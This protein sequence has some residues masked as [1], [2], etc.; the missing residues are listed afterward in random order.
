MPSQSHKE[1]GQKPG[2]KSPG[3][4]VT[5]AQVL[6]TPAIKALRKA[7]FDAR[8]ASGANG[9]TQAEVDQA[10]QTLLGAK[11]PPYPTLVRVVTGGSN[12]TVGPLLTDW[13]RR[14]GAKLVAAKLLTENAAVVSSESKLNQQVSLLLSQIEVTLRERLRGSPDPLQALI[15]AAQ[16]GEQHGIK[17]QLETVAADRDRLRQ[18]LEAMTF[19]LA[20]LEARLKTHATRRLDEQN[21]L[22]LNLERLHSSLEQ[23]STQIDLTSQRPRT[24]LDQLVTQARRVLR[25][26]KRSQRSSGRHDSARASKTAGSSRRQLRQ[27]KS[28][29]RITQRDDSARKASPSRRARPSAQRP[30]V[31]PRSSKQRPRGSR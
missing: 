13:W 20:E 23:V 24:D 25:G 17:T 22:E 6:A 14:F 8:D 26:L 5:A 11:L 9:V 27:R 10:A 31:H 30:K 18:Q 4:Q 12:S 2:R 7:I 21:S 1:P 28:S 3:P 15:A 29:T 19:K 16:L